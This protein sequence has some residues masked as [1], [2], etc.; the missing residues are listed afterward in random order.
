MSSN[1]H[2]NNLVYVYFTLF[3]GARSVRVRGSERA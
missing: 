2:K 1:H 3:T